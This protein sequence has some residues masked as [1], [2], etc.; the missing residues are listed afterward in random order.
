MKSKI[1]LIILLVL[2]IVLVGLSI[3]LGYSYLKEKENVTTL[4]S[5]VETLKESYDQ[6]DEENEPSQVIEQVVEKEDEKLAIPK[7]D[8]NKEERNASSVQE[9]GMLLQSGGAVVSLGDRST[10]GNKSR[11]VFVYRDNNYVFGENGGPNI[12]D[13]IF[14]TCDDGS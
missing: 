12:I 10:L 3:F 1:T 5:E 14:A 7:F 11:Q 4:T 9:Q 2:I 6:K 13:A 8:A